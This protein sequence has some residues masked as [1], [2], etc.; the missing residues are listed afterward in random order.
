MKDGSQDTTVRLV[1]V[2]PVIY[3]AAGENEDRMPQVLWGTAVFDVQSNGTL[4][5]IRQFIMTSVSNASEQFGEIRNAFV[6]TGWNLTA[7]ATATF[8]YNGQINLGF[9]FEGAFTHPVVSGQQYLVTVIG[10]DTLA[11]QVVVAT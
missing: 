9:S 7:G 10:T 5:P 11:S 4:V 8:T 1:I 3:M 6:S 2:S